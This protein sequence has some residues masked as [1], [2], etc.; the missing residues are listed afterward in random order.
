MQERPAGSGGAGRQRWLQSTHPTLRGRLMVGRLTLDQEVGVRVPAPQLA[1]SRITF[2]CANPARAPGAGLGRMEDPARLRL[3]EEQRACPQPASRDSPSR[4]ERSSSPG[5][6]A[7]AARPSLPAVEERLGEPTGDRADHQR[8]ADGEAVPTK[9]ARSFG[10]TGG[11]RSDARHPASRFAGP[12]TSPRRGIR[13]CRRVT[14]RADLPAAA[15]RVPGAGLLVHGHRRGERGDRSLRSRS[16]F[17]RFP[18][19]S[20][21]LSADV[22]G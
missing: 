18:L 21:V 9:H 1:T 16:R 17:R 2:P 10:G 3:R 6:A 12:A 15:D 22:W 20:D 13:A 8:H 7:G 11:I 4:S 19:K 5:D 14:R